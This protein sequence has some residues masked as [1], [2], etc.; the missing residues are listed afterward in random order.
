MTIKSFLVKVSWSFIP[1]LVLAFCYW[2]AGWMTQDMAELSYNVE[3]QTVNGLTST[4]IEIINN[5][6]DIAIDELELTNLPKNNL[7]SSISEGAK[8]FK[9]KKWM[10]TVESGNTFKLLMVTDNDMATD[11]SYINSIFNGRYQVRSDD[12]GKL[13]WKDVLVSERGII[14]FNKGTAFVFWY[15]LP[16]ILT[17]SSVVG[18][19]LYLNR[20]QSGEQA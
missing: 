17:I 9:V 18:I 14:A 10:G 2:F 19:L 8:D 6:D 5:Q 12:N 15:F 7:Y 11:N 13:I 20:N 1:A 16:L 3:K 4:Y